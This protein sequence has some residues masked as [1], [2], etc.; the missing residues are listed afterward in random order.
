MTKA[1]HELRPEGWASK[2]TS[3]RQHYINPGVARLPK[4]ADRL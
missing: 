4:E 3:V 1:T 2:T